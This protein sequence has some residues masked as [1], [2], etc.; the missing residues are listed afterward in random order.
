RHSRDFSIRQ[1]G[2]GSRAKNQSAGIRSPRVPSRRCCRGTTRSPRER[3]TQSRRDRHAD[4]R[5][6]RDGHVLLRHRSRGQYHPASKLEGLMTQAESLLTEFDAEMASTRKLLE[7]VP[8][9]KSDWKPHEKSKS[10]GDLA[11]HVANLL[12][13]L[14]LIAKHDEFDAMNFQR[15][16]KFSTTAKL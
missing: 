11:T 1:T 4:R 7:R 16:P 5:D 15:P 3:R 13:F 14:P 12:S 9:A 6:R 8:E 10:L 2:R